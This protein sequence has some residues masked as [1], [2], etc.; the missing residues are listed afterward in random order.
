M[1]GSD[2]QLYLRVWQEHY[3]RIFFS[4]CIKL[5]D[6]GHIYLMTEIDNNIILLFL[7]KIIPFENA[8]IMCNCFYIYFLIFEKKKT[9][10]I[11]KIYLKVPAIS[12]SRKIGNETSYFVLFKIL[13][14]GTI[15]TSV[16]KCFY[17]KVIKNKI[18]TS[19]C[20]NI[21]HQFV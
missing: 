10:A 19:L 5:R 12:L 18:L 8:N 11:S 2:E 15:L 6:Y 1:T 4:N 16:V 20:S 17:V 3:L 9:E 7:L 14:V 13:E 21:W